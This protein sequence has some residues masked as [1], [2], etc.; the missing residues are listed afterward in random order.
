M[1]TLTAARSASP[2]TS[3]GLLL[4]VR[5]TSPLV[6]AEVAGVN[7]GQPQSPEVRQAL[8]T[9]LWERGVLFFHDQHL[10]PPELIAATSVFGE[11]K[12]ADDYREG[13]PRPGVGVIDSINEISGRVSRWHADLTCNAAPPT[14]R[15]LQAIQ[16]PEIGGDTIWASTQAAY[17]RLSPPL[18]ALA[19]QLTAIH[20]LTPIRWSQSDGQRRSRFHWSEHPIVRVHPETGRKALFVNPRF[21]QE[22]PSLRPHE[23]AGVLK[24]FFDHIVQPEHQV[25]FQWR[26]GSLAVWDNRS[27]V[28]YAPDDYGAARRVMYA[29]EI[30]PGPATALSQGGAQ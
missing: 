16:L 10:S 26:L 8:Q 21:T 13:S 11:P 23:S 18:Q 22:I 7:L 15:L 14:V 4:E 20:A 27:T 24:V 29:S 9:L 6:G 1:T 17:E 30:D 25:R 28:H 3:S 12:T 19:E 5:L 2:P